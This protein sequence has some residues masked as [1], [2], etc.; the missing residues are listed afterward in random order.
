MIEIVNN[1]L[2]KMWVYSVVLHVLLKANS[3]YESHFF[4]YFFMFKVSQ[5]HLPRHMKLK[6][7]LVFAADHRLSIRTMVQTGVQHLQVSDVWLY[8]KLVH[9]PF[10]LIILCVLFILLVLYHSL[11]YKNSSVLKIWNFL[12]CVEVL[13]PNQQLSSCRAG[14]PLT[15]FLG[16][17]KPTKRL[18]ST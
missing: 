17:L 13:Q 14:F 16:R 10:I 9:V 7:Q 11:C 15:L 6:F 5:A 18:T 4:I 2:E 3:V 8:P 12:L 1:L